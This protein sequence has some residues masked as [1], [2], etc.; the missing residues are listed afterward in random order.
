MPSP[1]RSEFPAGLRYAEL[2]R[3]TLDS[4]RQETGTRVRADGF[5]LGDVFIVLAGSQALIE[6]APALAEERD[7]WIRE[8]RVALIDDGVLV[9]RGDVYVFQRDCAFSAP[10]RATSA[11][12]ARSASGHQ[13]WE[14]EGGTKLKDL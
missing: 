11:I 4:S 14:D 2:T 12:L 9:Q 3:L 5:D 6:E 13:E 10:A 8:L 7:A 1:I